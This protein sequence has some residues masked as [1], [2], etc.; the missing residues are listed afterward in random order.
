MNVL[1]IPGFN[2][3]QFALLFFASY[4]LRADEYLLLD[5]FKTACC[6]CCKKMAYTFVTFYEEQF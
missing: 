6:G 4:S 5:V 1:L 3:S 2:A